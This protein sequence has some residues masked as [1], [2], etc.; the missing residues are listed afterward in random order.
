MLGTP[1]RPPKR[2]AEG[3][4]RNWG[5]LILTSQTHCL[6]SWNKNEAAGTL[7]W[8]SGKESQHPR[9]RFPPAVPL[10]L[11]PT[12][13]QCPLPLHEVRTQSTNVLIITLLRIFLK[14]FP[15]RDQKH[16]TALKGLDFTNILVEREK[17]DIFHPL[18]HS[19]NGHNG[20]ASARSH[21]EAGVGSP[22]LGHQLLS[23]HPARHCSAWTSRL[24]PQDPPMGDQ[25]E[26]PELGF[27]LWSGPALAT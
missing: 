16:Q 10:H 8:S 20:Q 9:L 17:M 18:V 6:G 12:S 7:N 26:A 22:M 13:V 27:R 5:H 24:G 14:S 4:S 19:P 15:A 11:H 2:L 1:P 23:F 3:H 21:G 25:E